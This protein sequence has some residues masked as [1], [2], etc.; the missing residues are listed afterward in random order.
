MYYFFLGAVTSE[1]AFAIGV[2]AD[3]TFPAPS[4]LAAVYFIGL[5]Q[6]VV[7]VMKT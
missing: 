6:P 7:T 3:I 2:L 4:F 1:A 5:L